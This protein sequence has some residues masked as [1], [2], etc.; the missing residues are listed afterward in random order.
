MRDDDFTGIRIRESDKLQPY[1]VWHK[2][3]IVW[4]AKTK[5]AAEKKLREAKK[6]EGSK[7]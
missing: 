6:R 4:F 2:G 1:R 7:R 3:N 5:S